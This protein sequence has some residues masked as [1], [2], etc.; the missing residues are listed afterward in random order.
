MN[1]FRQVDIF[2]LL[3]L[4]LAESEKKMNGDINTL[5]CFSSVKSCGLLF[6]SCFLL[7]RYHCGGEKGAVSKSAGV[8]YRS[9]C[10]S[11][12]RVHSRQKS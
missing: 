9:S 1:H 10:L 11:S 5:S 3:Q 12:L 2:S 7:L 4:S 8:K 6:L